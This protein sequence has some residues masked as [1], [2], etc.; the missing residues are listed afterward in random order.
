MVRWLI[1]GQVKDEEYEKNA[2]DV[3]ENRLSLQPI[4]RSDL[5][6]NFTCQARNTDLIEPK[7]SSITLELNRE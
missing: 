3:I 2:G 1:N 5:G 4:T 7:E 6:S